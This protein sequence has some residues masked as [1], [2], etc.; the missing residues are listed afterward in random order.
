MDNLRLIEKYNYI[1]RLPIEIILN[2]LNGTQLGNVDGHKFYNLISEVTARKDEIMVIYLK[3]C[4][5]PFS[6]YLL[7]D[8]RK[9]NKLDI[10]EKKTD[11]STN[12]YTITIPDGN[13]NINELLS[14][15]K[16]LMESAS[17]FSFKY[18][19]TFDSS[20]GKVSFLINSGT[21]PLNTVL[22]FSTGTNIN[23]NC[24]NL[25]GFS[26]I[27]ITFT[28]SSSAI[29]DLVIDVADGFDG[30]H[31]K[32]NLVGSNVIT[33]ETGDSGSS[34]LLVVPI[35]LEPYSILYYSEL[36]NPFRHRI[37]Q[38]TI[39]Q[40][41]IKLVDS[42]D[43]VIDFNGLPYTFILQCEFVFNPLNTVTTDTFNLESKDKLNQ[44]VKTNQI[45]A[46]RILENQNKQIN[47]NN[48]NLKKKQ[49]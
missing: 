43:N 28:T 17:T 9:N 42:S 32:S 36:G 21:T 1:P 6:F 44:Q 20:T 48:G 38:S 25:I 35:T 37:A 16:S 10:T 45:L 29:S 19:I 31:V 33:T 24:H 49:K 4:F 39:K 47:G 46:R 11:N 30:V 18:T 40:I 34:E 22:N 41:E 13:Y 7:S 27:D 5:L 12:S 8:N 23:H 15:I 26:N 14:K 2:S 3:K